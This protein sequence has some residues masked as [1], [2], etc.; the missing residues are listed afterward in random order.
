MLI[1]QRVSPS[2]QNAP[3]F[4]PAHSSQ[5]ISQKLDKKSFSFSVI[6]PDCWYFRNCRERSHILVLYIVME[7]TVRQYFPYYGA[8]SV[9]NL[10]NV[11]GEIR[12]SLEAQMRQIKIVHSSSDRFWVHIILCLYTTYTTFSLC[13]ILGWCREENIRL[14]GSNLH[15]NSKLVRF[16]LITVATKFFCEKAKQKTCKLN[17]CECH[18]LSKRRMV[19]RLFYYIT[20]TVLY[21]NYA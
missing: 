11:G 14:S 21:M 16:V 20:C 18:I 4:P 9:F 19:W 8:R 17:R 5:G 10:T 2:P 3:V 15:S 1:Y 13:I 7:F 6:F 12:Q